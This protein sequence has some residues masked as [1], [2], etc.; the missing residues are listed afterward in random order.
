MQAVT[1]DRRGQVGEGR[2]RTLCRYRQASFAIQCMN[3]ARRS[4]SRSA[5][6]VFVVGQLEQDSVEPGLSIGIERFRVAAVQRDVHR[7]TGFGGPMP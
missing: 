4:S 1:Q 6:W 5:S 2:K 3:S 7:A